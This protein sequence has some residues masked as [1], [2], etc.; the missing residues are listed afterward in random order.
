[1]AMKVLQHL[2][3]SRHVETTSQLVVLTLLSWFGKV[4][5]MRMSRSSLKIL[6]PSKSQS[7][8]QVEFL[9]LIKRDLLLQQKSQRHTT[10][11]RREQPILQQELS[12]LPQRLELLGLRMI[13]MV[14][15]EVAKS[16]PKPSKRLWASLTSSLV[17]STFSSKE[18]QWMRSQLT[19]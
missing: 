2:L 14:L 12:Q 6:D 15:T 11:A 18:Y 13:Q 8:N 1:M 9:Q 4:I 17:R 7:N 19:M 16:L 10:L 5:L 3:L